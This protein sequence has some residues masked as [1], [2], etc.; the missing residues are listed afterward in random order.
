[1]SIRENIRLIART[2]WFKLAIFRYHS[3][4]NQFTSRIR[5]ISMYL[6]AEWKSV[7]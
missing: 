4:F 2:P 7:S 3:F 5:V 1:M 6:Q